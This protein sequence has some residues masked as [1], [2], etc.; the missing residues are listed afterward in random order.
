MFTGIVLH[1]LLKELDFKGQIKINDVVRKDN[2]ISVVFGKNFLTANL[3]RQSPYISLKK[4]KGQG[5]YSSLFKGKKI[6]KIEQLGLD[7]VLIVTL[8]E[9]L[10]IVFEIFGRRSDC[11]LVRDDK[12]MNSFKGVKR[13]KYKL[14]SIPKGLD[15]LSASKDELIN[16]IINEEKINGLTV[17]YIKSL[18]LKGIDFVNS[19]SIRKFGPTVYD[20]ILSPFILPEGK[21]FSTMNEAIIYYFE[22]KKREE[23]RKR[24]LEII[25]AQL[26]KQILKNEKILKELSEPKDIFVYKQMG[27]AILTYREVI[28]FSK[29]KV[30]L[31]YLD[32]KL[33]IKLNPSLTVMENAQNYFKLFK[34]EKKKA[35]SDKLRKGK[36]EKELKILKKKRKK[37]NTAEDLTEFKEFCK[38]KKE[39]KEEETFPSKFRVFTT[40]YGSKVLVGKSAEANHELTFSFARPYDIFLHVKNAPGSHTI[41]R[42]KDKNKFP[43]IEDIHQAAF[44]AARFSKLKHSKAVPVSY[45]QKRYVRGAKG[46]AKGTVI[47]EREK[48]VYVNPTG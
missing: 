35:E 25:E 18:K 37:L 36:I 24:L 48:V 15:I 23:E 8:E 12:V 41:L 39:E 17:G 6:S 3:N 26:E 44:Y 7:R 21:K 19:F 34:K 22:E 29:D 11:L 30:V 10:R 32:N 40:S 47:M 2:L 42:V 14:P 27:D 33:A 5:Y 16:A 9:D 46:L 45:A 13:E 43:P 1:Y 28:D 20:D 38:K 4:I 31:D